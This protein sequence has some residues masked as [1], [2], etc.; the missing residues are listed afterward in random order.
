[1]RS[2]RQVSVD[3]G[4]DKSNKEGIMF[5]ETSAKAG[6]NVKALFRKIALALPGMETAQITPASNCK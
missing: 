4:E 6:F 5:I 2:F 1:M 3:E